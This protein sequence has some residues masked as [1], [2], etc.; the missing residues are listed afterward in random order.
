MK[1]KEIHGVN[2]KDGHKLSQ[3]EF[4]FLLNA[5]ATG[6]NLPP[7]IFAAMDEYEREHYCGLGVHIHIQ[8][9]P[10]KV[11]FLYERTDPEDGSQVFMGITMTL[12]N[13]GNVKTVAEYEEMAKRGE[14]KGF[15]SMKIP[16]GELRRITVDEY[17]KQYGDE[18]DET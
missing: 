15:P 7:M 9:R 12:T 16:A 1:S 17:E 3:E 4:E 14:E 10:V 8:E 6:A 5:D 11:E 13:P 18:E 2:V